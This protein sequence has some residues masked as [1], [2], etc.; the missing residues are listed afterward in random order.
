MVCMQADSLR[1]LELRSSGVQESRRPGIQKVERR[2]VLRHP[3][4]NSCLF[5]AYELGV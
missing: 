2:R 1:R 5:H 3:R 4:Y